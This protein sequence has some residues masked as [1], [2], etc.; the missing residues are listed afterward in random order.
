L[1]EE[2]IVP[3]ATPIHGSEQDEYK[4]GDEEGRPPPETNNVGFR[5]TEPRG[6]AT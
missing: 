5:T 3:V 2:I 1:P 4:D 6:D